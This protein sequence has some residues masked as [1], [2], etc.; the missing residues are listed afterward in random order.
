MILYFSFLTQK[1][2]SQQTTPFKP[3]E[4]EDLAALGQIF[5]M[6]GEYAHVL[7]SNPAYGDLIIDYV[8]QFRSDT[9]KDQT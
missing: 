6:L 9:E 5:E 4:K 3:E 8:N 7:Q 2:M 1:K